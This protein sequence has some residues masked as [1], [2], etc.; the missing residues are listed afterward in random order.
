MLYALAAPSGSGKTSIAKE[1][2]KNNP[3]MEFSISVTTRKQRDIEID[4]KDYYF[5]T[6]EEFEN[7]IRNEEFIEYEKIFDGN[8]Y[9]TLKSA[10]EDV[11]KREKS[12]LFDV[13]V[14][15]AL[16]LKKHFKDK[17]VLIFIEPPSKE[18][19]EKRLRNRKTETPE[20]IERRLSRFDIELSKINEF[21][22]IVINDNL[23]IA[24]QKVQEIIDKTKI[25]ENK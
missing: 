24:V 12:M 16:S 8:Y 19:I 14:L 13:D 10:V 7:K 3:E 5:I 20:Q 17:A 11:I 2:L 18:E 9:G 21:D 1:I 4:G 6:K 23:N 25:K 15:G 22:Y